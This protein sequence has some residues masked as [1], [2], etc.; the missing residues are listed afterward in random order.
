ME[1]RRLQCKRCG[2]EW[3][4]YI[5]PKSCPRCHSYKWDQERKYKKHESVIK[6]NS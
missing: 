2:H 6:Q 5:F 3:Q 4:S 1:S